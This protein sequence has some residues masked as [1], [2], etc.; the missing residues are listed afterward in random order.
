MGACS[1]SANYET[2]DNGKPIYDTDGA[3][4]RQVQ[5]EQN[6]HIIIN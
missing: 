1:S 4:I 5:S 2:N 6:Y 3:L